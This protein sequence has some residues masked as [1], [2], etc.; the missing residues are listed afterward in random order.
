MVAMG[1]SLADRAWGRDSAVYRV[2]GVLNVIGG[3]FVTAIIAFTVSGVIAMLLHFFEI[4]ALVPLVGLLIFFIYRTFVFHRMK[5]KSKA[6]FRSFENETAPIPA[7]HLIEDTSK[8]VA[9]MLRNVATTYRNAITGL[10][11]EDR[12]LILVS[13]T[14]LL[15]LQEQVDNLRKMT[16]RSI[17]RLEGQNTEA[18]RLFLFVYD[19]EQDL[20]QSIGFIVESCRTH[21]ENSHKP[22]LPEQAGNLRY[23]LEEVETYLT[24]V[25]DR[26]GEGN[27]FEVE[28]LKEQKR[29]LVNLLEEQLSQQISGIQ[30]N[31]YGRRNS[32]LMFSLKLE[33]KDIV[34]AAHRFVK[35]Y[36]RIGLTPKKERVSMIEELV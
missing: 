28:D 27:F 21:I 33:T 30:K 32:M 31:G 29:N 3:W 14:G 13:V 17:K 24:G 7:H 16:Y 6:A 1:A 11:N 23:M 36:N 15:T 22:V 18:G 35:L 12:S 8:N 9:I 5:E 25:A 26:V 34:A 10:V 19:L 4:Y 20:A 2:A